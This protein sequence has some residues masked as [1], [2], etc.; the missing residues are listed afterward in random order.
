MSDTVYMIVMMLRVLR[1]YQSIFFAKPF[2][3][4]GAVGVR[5]TWY[6]GPYGIQNNV[7]VTKLARYITPPHSGADY[8]KSEDYNSG[9]CGAI[10][11][12]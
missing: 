9:D 10:S 12:I 1:R 2:L 3:L 4:T 6:H 11:A 5:D 8:H 7:T